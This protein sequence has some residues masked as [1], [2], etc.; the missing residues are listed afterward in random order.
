MLSRW[1]VG[2][3]H[4]RPAWVLR[5]QWRRGDAAA[6]WDHLPANSKAFNQA[7]A[8]SGS[9]TDASSGS[10]TNADSK[11]YNQANATSGS[12]TNASSGPDTNADSGSV[13]DSTTYK[14]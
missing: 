11:A 2:M 12:V 3:Q 7:N 4:C 5:L 10:G 9:V 8:T 14:D 1:I 13:A 6:S